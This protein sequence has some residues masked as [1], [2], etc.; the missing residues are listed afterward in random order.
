MSSPN[1]TLTAK[2]PHTRIEL[3]RH[4]VKITRPVLPPLALSTLFRLLALL[5]HA[6]LFGFGAW[7]L[8]S[9]LDASVP[10][11]LT[12]AVDGNTPIGVAAPVSLGFVA[13]WLVALSLAKGLLRYLEQYAGHYVAFR[14]LALLRNY[15]FDR[16]EPQAPAQTEG[17]DSG[18]LMNRVTKD[19]DRIEVFFAHTIAPITTAVIAPLMILGYLGWATSWAIALTLLP[20]LLL[21]GV[22]VPLLGYRATDIAATTVRVTRGEIAHHMTDSVQGVREVLLF[23]NQ[24]ARE[25]EL[26]VL[27]SRITKGLRTIMGFI[28]VRR[29]INQGLLAGAML[30]VFAVG[31]GQ[32]SAG[33]LTFGQLGLALGVA[34]GAFA[35]VLA[36]E[37]F[38]ADLDQAYASARRVFAV[39]ERA[40]LVVS[41]DKARDSEVTGDADISVSGLSFTYPAVA[42]SGVDTES[43]DQRPEV[44]HDLNLTIQAGKTTAIVGASG[45]GKSTLAALLDRMWD[46]TSGA[47]RIGDVDVRDLSLE[48][49]RNVV[50]YA[51]QRPHIFNDSIRANLLLAAPDATRE[52]LDDVIDAVGLRDWVNSEPEGMDTIVGEM[53]ERLSGGQRQR[54]AIARALLRRAPITILDEATSQIDADTEQVVLQGIHQATAGRTLVVIAHR[55]STVEDADHIIVMDEGRVVEQGAYAELIAAGGALSAL[56][57]REG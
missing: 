11:A 42:G 44:L 30:A 1:T 39:T 55:I 16:L 37:D 27:E 41:P 46:P 21:V 45:S 10:G 8:G 25:R 47:I 18:D 35:P 53:G 23:A 20:F 5:V 43:H 12:R 28:A 51:P 48:H 57:Q 17:M 31:A 49:L 22:V 14:S 4:L 9:L 19:I 34:L 26:S 15:F 38:V 36:V 50:A 32:V 13:A 29:G 52:D 3:S 6:A 7:A 56:A 54:L 2:I 40:P 33:T 24:D